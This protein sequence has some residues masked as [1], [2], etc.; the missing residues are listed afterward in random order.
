M[1]G[2]CVYCDWYDE[3]NDDGFCEEC[4][5]WGAPIEKA[6]PPSRYPHLG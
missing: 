3:L 6:K 5:I 1:E 2:V 4:V